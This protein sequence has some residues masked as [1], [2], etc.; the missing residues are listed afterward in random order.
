MPTLE[1]Q[2]V[3]RYRVGEPERR[4]VQRLPVKAEFVKQLAM[5]LARTAV[6]RVAEQRMSDRGHVD[7]DLVGAAG[8]EAAFDQRGIAED[9]FRFQCVTA[10]LPR[11]S[12]T[13]A[14]FLRLADERARGA[15]IVPSAVFGTPETIAR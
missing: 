10:R 1:R 15:S 4:R 14:I 6:D 11:P 2:T 3:L 8:F 9:V 5:S 13:I 7:A 12:A